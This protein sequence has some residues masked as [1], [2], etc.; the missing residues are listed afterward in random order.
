MIDSFEELVETVGEGESAMVTQKRVRDAYNSSVLE[1][2]YG[3]PLTFD[4]AQVFDSHLREN[5]SYGAAPSQFDSSNDFFRVW[6]RVTEEY[7]DVDIFF[8]GDISEHG[9]IDSVYLVYDSLNE[10][11]QF[12]QFCVVNFKERLSV[13]AE[14]NEGVCP[15]CNEQVTVNHISDETIDRSD[16]LLCNAHEFSARNYPGYGNAIRLWFDE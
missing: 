10:K 7:P 12:K 6:E 4:E 9:Y 3:R 13:Y 11:E 8:G 16:D 1:A 5:R 2:D 14:D 15:F